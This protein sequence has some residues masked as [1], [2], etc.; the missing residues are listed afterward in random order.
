MR[1]KRQKKYL[2]YRDDWYAKDWMGRKLINN[3]NEEG[4]HMEQEEE[5]IIRYDGT[6]T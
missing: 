3:E 6:T 1:I 2:K 5:K 4:I